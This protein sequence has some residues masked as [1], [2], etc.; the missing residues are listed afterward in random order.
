MKK[1]IIA[2]LLVVLLISGCAYVPSKAKNVIAANYRNVQLTNTRVQ[3]IQ[4]EDLSD[5]QKLELFLSSVK[6]WWAAD[7]RTWKAMVAWSEGKKS[8]PTPE[9]E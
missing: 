2:A 8:T 7:E 3:E 5:P 6:V 9:G 4:L 1:Q